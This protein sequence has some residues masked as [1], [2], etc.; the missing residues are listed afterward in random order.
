MTDKP[1]Y[2]CVDTRKIVDGNI[3]PG[4]MVETINVSRAASIEAFLALR[5]VKPDR[6]AIWR[7][8]QKIGW[9]CVAFFDETG[10]DGQPV[11]RMKDTE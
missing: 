1:L 11:L 3:K 5:G 7:K 8:A 10:A 2:G 6:K 4:L 9:R